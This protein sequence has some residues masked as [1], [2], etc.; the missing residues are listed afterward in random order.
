MHPLVAVYQYM[1]MNPN[2]SDRKWALL[3][4]SA[5]LTEGGGLVVLMV[6]LALV[7]CHKT[8]SKTISA[9]LS[10]KHNAGRAQGQRSGGRNH[11]PLCHSKPSWEIMSATSLTHTHTKT[12]L[13]YLL[14][15]TMGRISKSILGS[16]TNSC[17]NRSERRR[18]EVL[19]FTLFHPLI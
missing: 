10:L 15:C 3:Y 7:Y 5:N 8:N 11:W 12:Y 4:T 9:Y 16:G 18:G 2:P 6:C 19:H 14:C 13:G 1:E 17:V